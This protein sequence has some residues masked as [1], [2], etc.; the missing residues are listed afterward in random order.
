MVNRKSE[1]KACW[2]ETSTTPRQMRKMRLMQTIREMRC[3]R[4][5]TYW[6]GLDNRLLRQTVNVCARTI[7]ALRTLIHNV[8]VICLKHVQLVREELYLNVLRLGFEEF[9]RLWGKSSSGELF[10]VQERVIDERVRSEVEVEREA[11]QSSIGFT[12]P[13]S[14]RRHRLSAWSSTYCATAT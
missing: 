10:D 13:R 5:K 11:F 9:N 2:K 3:V 8:P 6:L 12:N 1:V 4:G 14:E 7:N